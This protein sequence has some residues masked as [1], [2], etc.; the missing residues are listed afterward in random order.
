MGQQSLTATDLEFLRRF[1]RSG[2]GKLWMELLQR[3]LADTDK[4]LRSTVG[5]DLLRQQGRA[6]LLA[7]LIDQVDKAE[8]PFK[9]KDVT[10]RPVAGFGVTPGEA[11]TSWQA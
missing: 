4:R 10:R 9:R 3:N 7:E 6:Q 5:D 11:S 2:E 1:S 8:E